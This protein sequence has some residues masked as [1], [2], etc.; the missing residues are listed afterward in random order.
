MEPVEHTFYFHNSGADTIRQENP[1]PKLIG[2][3]QPDHRGPGLGGERVP[4][5][6]EVLGRIDGL[7]PG[8]IGDFRDDGG[9][10]GQRHGNDALGF[11]ALVEAH[12]VAARGAC[13]FQ[14][15]FVGVRLEEPENSGL[16][17]EIL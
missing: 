12:D 3:D 17:C 13:P 11:S 5:Q 10:D 6:R 15:G 2:D 14:R 1:V 9:S 8:I 4:L 7:S 16:E